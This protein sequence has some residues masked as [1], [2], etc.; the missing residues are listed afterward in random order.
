MLL[1]EAGIDQNMPHFE[2]DLGRYYPFDAYNPA[3]FEFFTNAENEKDLIRQVEE[4][5][6]IWREKIRKYSTN[7]NE[8]QEIATVQKDRL[9]KKLEQLNRKRQKNHQPELH[10]FELYRVEEIFEAV[11]KMKSEN[12][13][14]IPVLYL[15]PETIFCDKPD[16]D[17]SE[18]LDLDV[19]AE[20]ENQRLDEIENMFVR[21][22]AGGTPLK[23]ED[24]NYSILKAHMDTPFQ[25]KLEEECEYL[26]NPARFITIAYRLFKM[27][28][29]KHR[30]FYRLA[31]KPRDFQTNIRKEKDDEK[32]D[33]FVVFLKEILNLNKINSKKSILDSAEEILVYSKKN[34]HGL[35]YLIASR[36]SAQAPEVMFMLLYRLKNK[37]DEFKIDSHL[38]KKALGMVTL[39]SWLGKGEQKDHSQLLRNIFPAMI[40]LNQKR[41]WSYETVQRALTPYNG[42]HVLT[43]FPSYKELENKIAILKQRKHGKTNFDGSYINL[44]HFA[45]KIFS[46]RDLVLYA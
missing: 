45:N 8:F 30:N 4:W 40:H 14:R 46:D 38:H 18:Q 12:T 37:G 15:Q 7:G 9:E 6:K 26:F 42:K 13:I 39:F 23:G 43:P 35:P 2:A 29:Q 17:E 34:S 41:F 1:S 31:I 28:D 36:L 33:E 21:L 24:L 27:H 20:N 19:D 11:K 3:P 10:E 25:K 44:K 16:G 32:D 22:N 5:Q